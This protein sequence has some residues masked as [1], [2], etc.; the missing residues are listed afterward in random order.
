M[1]FAA[2]LRRAPGRVVTGAFILNSGVGKLNV[3]EDHAKAVHG[4]AAGAYPV[5][6]KVPPT[7]FVKALA[8]GEIA[9][10]GA[11]LAPIV[12]AGL[13]GLGL[14]TFAG[15]LVGMW[16]R[17]PGM[18]EA[19]SVKPTQ[20]G[21]A[22]AKDVWMLGIGTSLIIDAALSESPVTGETP[23]AEAKASLKAEAKAARKAAAKAAARARKHA[24]RQAKRAGKRAGN[25]IPG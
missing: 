16:W 9:L 11:L 6:A 2:K 8:V 15:G 7:P 18:H 13:A 12:P 5:L 25:L 23:R 21:I 17:T 19:G 4:M 3:S 22:I 14:T 10:G 24:E 20:Q 1:T